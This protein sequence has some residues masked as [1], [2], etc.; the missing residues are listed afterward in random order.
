[1]AEFKIPQLKKRKSD[2]IKLDGIHE[3]ECNQ[4]PVNRIVGNGSFGQP[5][6]EDYQISN[7]SSLLLKLDT[8]DCDNFQHL[9]CYAGKEILTGLSYLHSKGIP[10]RDLKPENILVSNQQYASFLGNT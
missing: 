4:L 9:V 6:G 7:L 1:M 10:H 3:F 2:V 5:F 8:Y